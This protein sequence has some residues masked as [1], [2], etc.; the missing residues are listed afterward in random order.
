MIRPIKRALVYLFGASVS[1]VERSSFSEHELDLQAAETLSSVLLRLSYS[2]ALIFHASTENLYD[3]LALFDECAIEAAI[4]GNVLIPCANDETVRM[5]FREHTLTDRY[6]RVVNGKREYPD[7][8]A[9]RFLFKD[10]PVAFSEIAKFCRGWDPGPSARN[11]LEIDGIAYPQGGHLPHGAPLSREDA[12]LLQ[13]AFGDCTRIYTERMKAGK[14][15]ATVLKVHPIFEFAVYGTSTRP[16]YAKLDFS[17]RIKREVEKYEAYVESAIPFFMRPNLISNRCVMPGQGYE[18]GLLVGNFVEHSEPII[19]VIERGSASLP[20]YSLFDHAFRTWRLGSSIESS[21]SL[22][23]SLEKGGFTQRMSRVRRKYLPAARSFGLVR[24]P[25][26]LF[27]M[28]REI[29]AGSHRKGVIHGDLHPDNIHVRGIDAVL[30]DFYCVRIGPLVYD[31]AMLEVA[32]VFKSFRVDD[33]DAWRR[34]VD[35]LYVGGAFVHPPEPRDHGHVLEN[36][37]IAVRQ[38]RCI[39]PTLEESGIDY[40]TAIAFCLIRNCTYESDS[41]LRAAYGLVAAERI[42]CHLANRQH[43]E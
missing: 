10:G 30:L 11:L 23:N 9:P 15:G 2:R 7:F 12:V 20:L 43:R 31:L 22:L 18:R 25:E 3:V 6:A 41:P 24:S 36:L 13:R 17:Q 16:M 32:T 28:L 42:L 33:F 34:L 37:W 8:I 4:H 1:E 19:S 39:A 14:S 38:L 35:D 40:P 26:A 29:P 5:R 27:E 21:D